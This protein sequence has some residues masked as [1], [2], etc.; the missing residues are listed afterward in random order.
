MVRTQGGPKLVRLRFEAEHAGVW[1]D[2]SNALAS[3]RMLSGADPKKEY[4]DKVRDIDL[5]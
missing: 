5:R 1:L 2:E 4:E 3:V